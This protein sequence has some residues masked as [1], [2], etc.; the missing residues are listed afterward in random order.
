[1]SMGNGAMQVLYI[2]WILRLN[3]NVKMNKKKHNTLNENIRIKKQSNSDR[4]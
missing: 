3:Q 2:G 1:M 4:N